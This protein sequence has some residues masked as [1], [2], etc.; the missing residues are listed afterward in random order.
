MRK[1]TNHRNIFE[2]QQQVMAS[3][4]T[5]VDFESRTIYLVG[6]VDGHML[7]R[8]VTSFEALDKAPGPIR[9][10]LSTPGGSEPDGYAIYD[11]MRIANN[12]TIVEGYGAVQ[13]IGALILQAAD[14]RLLAP[15]CRVMV[16]NGSVEFGQALNTDTLVAIGQEVNRNNKRYQEALASRSNLSSNKVREL[17]DKETYMSAGECVQW[18]FADGVITVPQRPT[19]IKGPAPKKTKKKAVRK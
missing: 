19:L 17:I 6:E 14:I 9:V 1:K 4:N 5:G 10:V 15:E 7:H 8:F 16:H 11:L 18:G 2:T 3:M 12:P 13:S